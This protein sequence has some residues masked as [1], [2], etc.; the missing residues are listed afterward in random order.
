MPKSS[1]SMKIPFSP[2]LL[3]PLLPPLHLPPPPLLPPFLLPTLLLP[4]L[5]LPP[6]LLPHLSLFLLPLILVPPLFLPPSF[7]FP[8][9]CLSSFCLPSFHFLCSLLFLS[10]GTFYSSPFLINPYAAVCLFSE[11]FVLCPFCSI[12]LLLRKETVFFVGRS[13]SF[14]YLRRK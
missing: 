4:T 9:F 10:F 12:R 1:S 14:S 13:L 3:L 6:L 5:L 11:H 2:P 7:R 8:R